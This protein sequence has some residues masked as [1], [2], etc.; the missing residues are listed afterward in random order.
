V[1]GADIGVIVLADIPGA[2]GVLPG[3]MFDYIGI[4][5]PPLLFGPA[6][7]AADLARE[8]GGF[9]VDYGDVNAL[10]SVL[11]RAAARKAERGTLGIEVDPA[12]RAR[13]DRRAQVERVSALLAEAIEARS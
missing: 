2:S 9:A 5:V 8:C 4:G 7:A 11:S 12:V 1:A 10:A 3:K 6:G 13:F